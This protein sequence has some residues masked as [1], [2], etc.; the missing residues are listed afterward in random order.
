MTA[1]FS[2][3]CACGSIRYDCAAAPIAML[4]CHC[5][6][7]QLSSGAPF[8]S[9]VV[10]ASQ[11]LEVT[12]APKAYAVRAENHFLIRL[13]DEASATLRGAT[14][15]VNDKYSNWATEIEL[16]FTGDD[17]DTVKSTDIYR[18]LEKAGIRSGAN[19]RGGFYE[20]LRRKGV[21]IENRADGYKRLFGLKVAAY[22]ARA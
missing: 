10:V 11:D 4:N 22:L 6:D 19:E 14:S 2:G 9:G 16:V 21:R 12:G 15:D 1:P 5:R 17:K 3:G 7:C 18:A 8:A 13:N 20:Y